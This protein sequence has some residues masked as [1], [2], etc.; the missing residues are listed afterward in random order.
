MDRLGL[1]QEDRDP[2][3]ANDEDWKLGKVPADS[4]WQAA[5]VTIAT[6]PLNER[7]SGLGGRSFGMQHA[8]HT[9]WYDGARSSA[10]VDLL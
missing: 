8:I 4:Q 10:G 7:V 9:T 2:V 3:F 5:P 1:L 6:V